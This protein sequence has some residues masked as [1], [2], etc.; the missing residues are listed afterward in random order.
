ME[1][2]QSGFEVSVSKVF[3]YSKNQVYDRAVDWLEGQDRIAMKARSNGSKLLCEW[4]SDQSKVDLIITP[5][6]RKKTKMEV[7]HELRS[8]SD[9]DVM[10][11]FWRE[12]LP[13]M[14]ESL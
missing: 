7:A 5:Q 8:E 14:V 10:R 11:N 3:P 12:H 4:C 1:Q 13:R 9:A 6:G 2:E